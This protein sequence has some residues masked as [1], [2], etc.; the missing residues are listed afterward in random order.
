MASSDPALWTTLRTP[1]LDADSR[2]TPPPDFHLV[3]ATS[4]Y[5]LRMSR[6]SAIPSASA[7]EHRSHG[8]KTHDAL[9]IEPDHP[10]GALH[11][12]RPETAK[13]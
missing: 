3:K 9:T 6:V 2:P 4:R 13:D 11:P 5:H 12:K 1:L 7:R 10:L 8:P